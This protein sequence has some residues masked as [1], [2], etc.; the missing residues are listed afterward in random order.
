MV[1]PYS[2]G[3]PSDVGSG[4]PT[5]ENDV[6]GRI[7]LDHWS[8]RS[9]PH[10]IEQDDGLLLT[11]DSAASYFEAPRSEAERE[12]LERLEGP[13]LDL[14]C[15]PGSYALWLQ[16]RGLAVTAADASPGAI[17][18]C[19]RRGCR[20]ARL[21]DVRALDLPEGHYGS[22]VV[23]GNTLGLHQ[24]PGRLPTLLTALRAAT[25][26]GGRLLCMT[27]DPLATEVPAHLGYH[28]RN[29]ALGRPPGLTTVR[30]RYGEEVDEWVV[31]WLTTTEELAAAFARTG[32]I[33]SERRVS[34][35]RR[36][37]LYEAVVE[38]HTVGG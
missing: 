35:P 10:Q 11:V 38:N 32:W 28:R 13:V 15:G 21:M 8:G 34:G 6:W 37:D 24:D 5:V 23:M 25:R 7:Y 1:P 22:V 27:A 36:V 19:R 30:M 3:P 18:V 33:L 16:A 29:R 12:L 2:P 31:L 20:D 4:S 14:A 26:L 9:E 17:E